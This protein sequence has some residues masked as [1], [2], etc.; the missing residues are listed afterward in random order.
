[1]TVA[2]TGVVIS[3]EDQ[4]VIFEKFRQGGVSPTADNF[5]REFSGTGLGLSIIK[6]MCRILGGEISLESQIGVGSTF[7]VVL[8]AYIEP[9]SVGELMSTVTSQA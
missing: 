7:K 2:D 8:P 9:E 1:M 4:E 6:E 5:K 3:E